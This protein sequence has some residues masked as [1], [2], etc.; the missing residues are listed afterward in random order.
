MLSH[1]SI[2]HLEELSR[3]AGQA[4]LDIYKREDFGVEHK[5]DESPLTKADQASNRII[6]EG[7]RRLE[8]SYPIISEENKSIPF[9]E[10]KKYK[11]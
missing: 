7:L 5:K 6:C 4:I 9:E 3:K 2:Y 11:Y 8:E 1:S 10:R